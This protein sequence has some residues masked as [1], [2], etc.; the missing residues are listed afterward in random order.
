MQPVGGVGED[1]LDVGIAR[2]RGHGLVDVH[3]HYRGPRVE[4]FAPELDGPAL[5]DP[6]FQHVRG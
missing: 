3:P 5:L 2:K 4:E 1:G 6:Y